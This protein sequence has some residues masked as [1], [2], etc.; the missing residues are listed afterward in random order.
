MKKEGGGVILEGGLY[1][2]KNGSR[3]IISQYTLVRYKVY[4]MVVFGNICIPEYKA[5]WWPSLMF[6]EIFIAFTKNATKSSQKYHLFELYKVNTQKNSTLYMYPVL[7][8]FWKNVIKKIPQPWDMAI[9][10]FHAF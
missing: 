4:L 3:G 7:R 10:Q 6:G 1:G 2:S 9:S 5:A 8:G